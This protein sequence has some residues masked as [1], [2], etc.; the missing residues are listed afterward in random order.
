MEADLMSTGKASRTRKRM[1]PNVISVS[2]DQ[3]KK[4]TVTGTWQEIGSSYVP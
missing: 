1:R 4:T 3:Y 2:E